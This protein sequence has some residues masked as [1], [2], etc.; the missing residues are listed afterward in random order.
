M[1]RRASF[2]ILLMRQPS[3]GELTL[4]LL[5]RDKVASF[6][7]PDSLSD[8]LPFDGAQL[9]F[10][11]LLFDHIPDKLPDFTGFAIALFVANRGERHIFLFR[12]TKRNALL[13]HSI[14]ISE[15]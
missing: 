5:E 8:F 13:S 10:V 6:D 3:P 2:A 11:N 1:A 7:L 9:D 15:Q 12:K 4:H 14:L